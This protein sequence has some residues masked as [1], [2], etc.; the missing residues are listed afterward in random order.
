MAKA[1]PSRL[2]GQGARAAN[3]TPSDPPT[4][5]EAQPEEPMSHDEGNQSPARLINRDGGNDRD[6]DV[7]LSVNA[8]APQSA[9]DASGS[10]GEL[11]DPFEFM[12]QMSRNVG[13]IFESMMSF[14]PFA[15]S[16]YYWA[17]A[18]GATPLVTVA[19]RDNMMVVSADVPGISE[20]DLEIHI[21]PGVISLRGQ[22][23]SNDG[24]A[25]GTTSFQ[26]TVLL[27]GDALVDQAHATLSRGVLN[28]EL[29]LNRATV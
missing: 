6:I 3:R 1:V 12:Q 16:L 8:G 24:A 9:F 7:R 18:A 5:H 28:I 22:R 25:R 13:R 23:Q 15:N 4:R 29:P 2:R 11:N 26:R 14:N 17:T 27:P 20:D 21:E 19:E 10:E